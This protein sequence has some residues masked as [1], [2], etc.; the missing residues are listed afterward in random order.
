[1]NANNRDFKVVNTSTEFDFF[2]L[3]K[4]IKAK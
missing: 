3:Q 4:L 2:L 1:M